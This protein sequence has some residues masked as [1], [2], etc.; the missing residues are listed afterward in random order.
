[1]NDDIEPSAT[2]DSGVPSG[3]VREHFRVRLPE[4]AT[5]LSE[6]IF[7]AR[8]ASGLAAGHV[9]ATRTFRIVR[10]TEL[11][12]YEDGMPIEDLVALRLG[13][14][15][16]ASAVSDRFRGTARKAAKLS[17]VDAPIEEY[18]DLKDLIDTLPE[19]HHMVDHDP[20]ITT[21]RNSD[22]VQE[23]KRNVRVR[24]F[25]YA[26]S[27]ENDNDFHLIIGRDPGS[28]EMYM[29]VELSGLP[30]SDSP[31]LPTLR[32]ARDAYKEFFGNDLPGFSYD[33]YDPPIPV[34]VEGS[35]FF[36]MSHATGQRPGPSSLR[37]D[38]PTVWEI[39]PITNID[40]EP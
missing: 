11:D 3:E 17:I 15:S 37:D 30:P 14:L 4:G 39:H 36:D 26:S 10:T 23:E 27:R 13:L 34:S 9:Y 1:M 21:D 40:F 6:T 24:T 20:L 2:D 32:V 29:N 38:I 19:H 5:I 22:R 25:L 35:L 12:A 33:F 31:F 8:A 7:T 18:G 16:A 28:D